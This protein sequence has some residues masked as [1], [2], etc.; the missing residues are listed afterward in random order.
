[1]AS[2][3]SASSSQSTNAGANQSTVNG[4]GSVT[5]TVGYFS[6]MQSY[7]RVWIGGQNY[8][9]AGPTSM[10]QGASWSWSASRTY[11][12]DANGYRGDVGVS[13]EFWI[14]GT[15]LHAGSAGAATQGAIDYDRRPASPGAVGVTV[16]ADKTISVAVQA[17]SSPAGTPTYYVEYSQNSGS[18]VGQVNSTNPSF[19]FTGL[20]PGSNYQFR[21][22][23][24][25]SDGTGGTTYSSTVFLPSGGKRYTGTGFSP[26]SI[27]R[28]YTGTGW[29]DLSIAKRSTGTGWTD[30][31]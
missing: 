16:N 11:T 2:S 27:A 30:L 22:W 29:Q 21:A 19:T 7:G 28:R 6:G 1:M 4:Y 31:T 20:T 24:T 23:A 13:V 17:V 8:D 3:V 25:N 12:H 18:W 14:N 9:I 26:T 10:S 15:S 5:I